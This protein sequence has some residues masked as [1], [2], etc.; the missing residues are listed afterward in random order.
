MVLLNGKQIQMSTSNTLWV[1]RGREFF[2]SPMQK[3]FD[4]NDILS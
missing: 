2:N 3:W 1:D 4:V